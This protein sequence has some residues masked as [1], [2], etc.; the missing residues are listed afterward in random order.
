MEYYYRRPSL[1]L[2]VAAALLLLRP[3]AGAEVIGMPGC[4]TSCGNMSVPYPFGMGPSYCYHSPGFNLTCDRSS[5]PPRLLLGDGTLQVTEDIGY[6]MPMLTVVYTGDIKTD[7]GGRGRLGGLGEGGPCALMPSMN[8]LILL[9]C[10]V[11]ATLRSGNV[12]MS[13]CSSVCGKG[14]ASGMASLFGQD[15]MLC[16]GIGCCEAPIVGRDR[17]TSYYDVELQSLGQNRSD[18]QQW[19]ARVFVAKMGWFETRSVWKQLSMRAAASIQVTVLVEWEVFDDNHTAQLQSSVSPASGSDCPR[20]AARRVC[21]SDHTD[22][23]A[24]PRGGY[25]CHCKKGY[26]GNPYIT[27]GCQGKFHLT[28]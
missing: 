2:A 28:L 15:D 12:T 1:F 5:N 16:S 25:H 18:D 4:E 26:H 27:D 22:C 8:K 3:A 20:D 10:N 24:G 11:R 23:T 17:L 6:S 9:G 7:G 13:S 14:V 19:P 21:K